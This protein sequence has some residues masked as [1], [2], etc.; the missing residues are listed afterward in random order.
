MF[1]VYNLQT[2]TCTVRLVLSLHVLT[3]IS[4]GAKVSTL[5][6]EEG[7][8]AGQEEGQ[9]NVYS[10]DRM[11]LDGGPFPAAT[12]TGP[13]FEPDYRRNIAVVSKGKAVLNCR[14]YN[15][16]NRTVSH[17]I[18]SL[19]TLSQTIRSCNCNF[20][21]RTFKTNLDIVKLGHKLH[22]AYLSLFHPA[23]QM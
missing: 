23:I 18:L 16:G 11:V 8:E 5:D 10:M 1:R 6:E 19:L 4:G 3:L 22:T 2:M 9:T 12:P 17:V 20:C 7:Q 21:C 15:I 14:V 13:Y